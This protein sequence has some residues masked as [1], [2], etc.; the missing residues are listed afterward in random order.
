MAGHAR[1]TAR[2]HGEQTARL[3]WSAHSSSPCS[4]S[5]VEE[6]AKEA[7]RGREPARSLEMDRESSVSALTAQWQLES[8]PLRTRCLPAVREIP[9]PHSL[10]TSRCDHTSSS[11]NYRRGPSFLPEEAHGHIVLRSSRLCVSVTDWPEALQ[12]RLE[13]SPCSSPLPDPQPAALA[14]TT[15][16]TTRRRAGHQRSA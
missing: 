13:M 1:Q 5:S 7:Q 10:L 14:C 8:S 16:N 11:E 3:A 15:T 4:T 6:S 9:P 2:R 12:S